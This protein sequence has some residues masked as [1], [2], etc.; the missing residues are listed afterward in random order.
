[1]SAVDISLFRKKKKSLLITCGNV[2]QYPDNTEM[3]S[4]YSA[5]LLRLDV[6]VHLG[7]SQAD[8][9]QTAAI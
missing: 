3:S 1:M 7:H 5:F 6:F 8:W 4:Q 9:P 2:S